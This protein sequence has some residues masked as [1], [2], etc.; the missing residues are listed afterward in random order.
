MNELV[1]GNRHHLEILD[2]EL[3]LGTLGNLSWRRC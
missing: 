3:G 2:L 1:K